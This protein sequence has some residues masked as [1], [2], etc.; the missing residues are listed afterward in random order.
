MNDSEPRPLSP[1]TRTLLG[2]YRP[3]VEEVEDLPEILAS[4]G[5]RS[6]ALVQSELIGWIKSGVVTK[7][8]LERLTGCEVASDETARGFIE[9]FCEFL[10]TPETD[11]P[12][13]H[14]F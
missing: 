2:S 4:M 9:A 7:S 12:D 8:A 5:S 6:V 1:S 3:E 13:I 14:E 11:P 10:K